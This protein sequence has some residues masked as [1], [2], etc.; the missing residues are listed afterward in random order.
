MRM[1][2]NVVHSAGSSSQHYVHVKFG[3]DGSTVTCNFR[4][5]QGSHSE[6][7]CRIE[8]GQ[9]EHHLSLTAQGTTTADSPNTVEVNL[10]VSI[11]DTHCYHITA[12][13]STFTVVLNGVYSKC[14]SVYE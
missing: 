3:S 4:G 8:Y 2:R 14:H 9:C 7:S 12:S 11:E 13:N 5:L 10:L 1:Y 6:K